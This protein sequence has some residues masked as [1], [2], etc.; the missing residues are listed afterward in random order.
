MMILKF[1]H[2]FTGMAIGKFTT[3][4]QVQSNISRNKWWMVNEYVQ[5]VQV[6]TSYN[7]YSLRVDIRLLVHR[8]QF[9]VQRVPLMRFSR[10]HLYIDRRTDRETDRDRQ[11]YR[12]THT[13]T[14]I[15]IH[16]NT[17]TTC[18]KKTI[19]ILYHLVCYFINIQLLI[20]I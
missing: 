10:I 2:S 8:Q 11:I 15:H 20:Y 3:Q 17:I 4:R 12:H 6:L 16:T 13:H 14:Y 7:F 9:L 1:K 19:W 18:N 5:S